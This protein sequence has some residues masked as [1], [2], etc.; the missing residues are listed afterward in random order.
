MSHKGCRLSFIL[1]N[2]L[3]DDSQNGFLIL[4]HFFKGPRAY[5]GT[6]QPINPSTVENTPNG[7]VFFAPPPTFLYN[8]SKR[9][10][11]L[12]L[13]QFSRVK[14]SLEICGRT[15]TMAYERHFL[16]SSGIRLYPYLGIYIYICN[17]G[18]GQRCEGT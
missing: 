6:I 4:K 8:E 13:L 12:L 3:L 11:K 18:E 14:H 9:R 16:F 10:E 7:W 2:I 17:K 1:K 15:I 5:K